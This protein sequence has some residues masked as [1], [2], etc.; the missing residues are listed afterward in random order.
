MDP[1]S[2]PKTARTRPQRHEGICV[3][4]DLPSIIRYL[5]SATRNLFKARFANCKFL[6]HIFPTIPSTKTSQTLD[7]GALETLTM[8][9]N[10]P[11]SLTNTETSKLINLKALAEHVPDGFSTEERIIRSAIPGT[12]NILPRTE[13]TLPQKRPPPKTPTKWA[14]KQPTVHF[15]MESLDSSPK[16]DLTTLNQAKKRKNWPQW[17]MALE[18]EYSSLRKYNVFLDISDDLEKPPIG[19]KLIFTRKL[20]SQGR[21]IRYKVR[22]LAQGFIQRLGVDFDE[23]YSPV[24]NCVSFRYL[25]AMTIYLAL[26]I[27]LLDVVTANL[28]GT[29]DSVLHINPPPG[30]LESVP[31]PKPGRFVA[32][33]ILKALYGLKQSSRAWYH[34]LCHFLISQS[35]IHNPTLPCIFTYCT[36]EG[37][38]IIAVYVDNLNIIGTP[39]MC[40]FAQDIL[41]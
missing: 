31:K 1:S 15:T 20:N 38:V 28:H 32:L 27:Y 18:A 11:T 19:H 3:G 9:P 2:R 12:G 35:F 14:P 29:L 10:P 25:I 39:E 5:E 6:E 21:V 30:F 41:T 8:N 22:L 7:F 24:M 34:H 13:T 36:K 40:K 17:Q 16:T 26:K 33:R 4:Y 37:F 23:T